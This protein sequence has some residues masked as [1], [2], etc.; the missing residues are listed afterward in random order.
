VKSILIT[1][2]SGF[3]G[4]AFVRRLLVDNLSERICIYSRGEH[5][6]AEMRA[7]FNDDE[8]LRFLVGDV[9]DER[10][11]QRAMRS[12]DV[13]VH[14]AALKRI[15]IGFYNPLEM[16]MTNIDGTANVVE[17]TQDAG[18]KKAVLISSDK[19]HEAK[20]PYG[21][22]K[23]FAEGLFL[24]ANHT[25]GADGCRYAVCRY[26]NVFNSTGSVVPKWREMIAAGEREVPVTDIDCT[27]FMMKIEQAVDLVLNTIRTMNGGELAIP[28]LPAYRL[29]DLVEALGVKPWIIGLPRWEKLHE[30]MEEGKSSEFAR[31][32]TVDEL[33]KELGMLPSLKAAA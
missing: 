33:R 15:E 20:S 16:K 10:R 8:R 30:S 12:V 7:A 1:G 17:A 5:A 11:L 4:K 13:V 27:R 29:G 6:Q 23:A 21:T 19:A 22:S 26:G 28:T 2:G 32:M 9:R 24:A 18:V 3:L 14:A 25:T 31:R